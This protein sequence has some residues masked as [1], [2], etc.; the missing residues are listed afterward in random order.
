MLIVS[1]SDPWKLKSRVLV[2]EASLRQD[3][4]V[5]GA[6]Q[7]QHAISPAPACAN[8]PWVSG[9]RYSPLLL[10]LRPMQDA[11]AII[12]TAFSRALCCITG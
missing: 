4:T 2:V 9:T 3:I 10:V 11:S 8:Y 1:E 7:L 6:V 5:V 12:S